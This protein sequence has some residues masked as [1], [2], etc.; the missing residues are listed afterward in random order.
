[1]AEVKGEPVPETR[2]VT[3]Q[4]GLPLALSPSWIPD[5]S[6]RMALYKRIARRRM[7]PPS[8]RRPPPLT[9]RYG[10]PPPAFATASRRSRASAARAGP[11]REGAPE[12]RATSC[13]PRSKRTIGPRSPTAFS[14]G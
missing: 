8:M 7:P 9:D 2:D 11:G 6:L 5:E 12:A 10:A 3:L 1:M 14:P 4:L 13:T